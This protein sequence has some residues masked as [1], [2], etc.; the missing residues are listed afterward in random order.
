MLYAIVKDLQKAENSPEDKEQ[1]IRFLAELFYQ[2]FG[3]NDG[4]RFQT[5][6][7]SGII[8]LDEAVLLTKLITEYNIKYQIDPFK[9]TTTT[10]EQNNNV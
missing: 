7:L 2:Y 5:M 8:T 1:N 10:G 9:K 6:M 3:N 4:A